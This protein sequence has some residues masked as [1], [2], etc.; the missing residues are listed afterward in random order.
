MGL[1]KQYAIP[2]KRPRMV[3]TYLF[4]RR[5]KT[6]YVFAVVEVVPEGYRLLG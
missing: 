3:K 4:L 1:W 6:K 5:P 2:V